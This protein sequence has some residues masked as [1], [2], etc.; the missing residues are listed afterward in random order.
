MRKKGEGRFA[1]R[2][3]GR[4][5][6]CSGADAHAVFFDG[7]CEPV[8]PV[9][10][11]TFGWRLV[12]PDGQVLASGH[13]EVCR[14]P[15]ATNNVAEWHALLRAVRF[16][17]DQ[18]WKGSLQIHGDSPLVI[19]QLNGRWKCHKEELRRCRDEC[20]ELLA[21]LV[22]Q[23]LWV[24]RE[25]NAE[26]DALS[27]AALPEPVASRPAPPTAPPSSRGTRHGEGAP[28]SRRRPR[29]RQAGGTGFAGSPG[30]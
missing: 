30:P 24:P 18:G 7:A 20:L 27:R 2:Q 6:W 14:G 17:A 12:G 9:G 10:V 21:R 4:E 29:K 13:G 5:V 16:L 25:E 3:A 22:W 15:A 28:R 1:G 23:A 8:N 26:A 11:A 19:N